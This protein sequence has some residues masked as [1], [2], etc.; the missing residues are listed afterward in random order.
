MSTT[1]GIYSPDEDR[2]VILHENGAPDWSVHDKFE[3]VK[4]AFRNNYGSMRWTNPLAIY[5][6]DFLPVYALDNSHQGV[7][8]IK[9]IKNEIESQR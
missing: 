9:D 7:K 3:F 1:F 5:L 2:P 8:T 4:V 6:P